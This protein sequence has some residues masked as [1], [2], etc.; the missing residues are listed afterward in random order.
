V[1]VLWLG[2][3]VGVAAIGWIGMDRSP[4]SADVDRRSSTAAPEAQPRDG[5]LRLDRPDRR[6]E[7]IRTSTIAVRGEVG[8]DVTEVWLTLES[9]TGK[10][11]DT[12]TI[13]PKPGSDAGRQTFAGR[14]LD[15]RARPTG[16]VFV[17][18]TAIGRDGVPVGATR[19][20]IEIGPASDVIV[21]TATRALLVRGWV[22]SGIDDVRV[23]VASASLEPIAIAAIDPT[24]M[25][26]NGMVPF[27][28]VFRLPREAA[29][30]GRDL[31][32]VPV[33]GTGFPIARAETRRVEGS[34]VELVV[35]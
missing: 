28:A 31:Y 21:H 13:R 1:A 22:A 10:V 23:M 14:L 2:G 7:V 11:L 33:D 5:W 24:G 18:A 3:L 12:Q 17:M 34:I 20:R 16:R 19:R 15:G 25:P 4:S 9:R 8:Q 35:R 30:A 26:R 29:D 27:E 6:D 32:V